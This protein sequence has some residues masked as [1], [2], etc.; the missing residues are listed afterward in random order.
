[1][2]KR[3]ENSALMEKEEEYKPLVFNNGSAEDFPVTLEAD[4]GGEL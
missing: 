1:M 2:I 3:F 4:Q